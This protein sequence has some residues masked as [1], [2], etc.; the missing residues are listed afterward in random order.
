[1][2]FYQKPPQLLAVAFIAYFAF[3]AYTSITLPFFIG[4]EANYANAYFEFAKTGRPDVYGELVVKP[5]GMFLL[6]YVPLQMLLAAGSM[7]GIPVEIPFRIVS[8]LFGAGTIAVVYW[9]FKKLTGS[10]QAAA[11]GAIVFLINPNFLMSSATYYPDSFLQFFAFLSI[12][13]MFW[14]EGRR[15]A[16]VGG[17]F[18]GIAF[19]IKMQQAFFIFAIA[20]PLLYFRGRIRLDYLLFCALFCAIAL[21]AIVMPYYPQRMEQFM[22][23]ANTELFA[24]AGAGLG[25]A[26]SSI[27]TALFLY[28]AA[29]PFFICML[30]YSFQLGKKEDFRFEY[31]QIAILL[32]FMAFVN[33]FFYTS[34]LFFGFALLAGK[35][36]VHLWKFEKVAFF[37]LVALVLLNS[38]LIMGSFDKDSAYDYRSQKQLGEFLAGKYPITFVTEIPQMSIW[39]VYENRYLAEGSPLLLANMRMC[40]LPY[41]FM[42][43]NESRLDEIN[44]VYYN[45]SLELVSEEGTGK[46]G[47]YVVLENRTYAKYAKNLKG[48]ERIAAFGQEPGFF[49]YWKAGEKG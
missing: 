40:V 34:M 31:V 3:C 44:A 17:L 6:S 1:M 5:A 20:I 2:A 28:A 9:I 39:K 45:R 18:C 23:L 41:K 7:G 27:A 37:A 26:S 35:V 24:R 32:A 21:V 25:Y 4:D 48:Y 30:F 16:I 33:N 22:L 19:Y 11:A 12:A 46:L 36:Y 47:R 29:I 8:M 15:G 43:E 13:A 42:N 10:A 38:F 49:V 14:D